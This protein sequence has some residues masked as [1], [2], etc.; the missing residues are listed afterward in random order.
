MVTVQDCYIDFWYLYKIV[1]GLSHIAYFS[2][3]FLVPSHNPTIHLSSTFRVEK[4]G[5]YY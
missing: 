5:G 3:A 2:V 1:C 4:M